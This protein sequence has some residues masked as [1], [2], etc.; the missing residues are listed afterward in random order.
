MNIEKNYFKDTN[1]KLSWGEYFDRFT[2]NIR[3]RHYD[4]ENY[5]PKFDKLKKSI[6]DNAFNN[7][8]DLFEAVC[9][10]QMINTDIWN[11][12]YDIRRGKEGELGEAEV[13]R[14]AIKI[15]EKNKRRIELVNQINEMFDYHDKEKKFDH[16]SEG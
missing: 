9:E 13:G 11:L 1:I 12:E 5:G 7:A 8:A 4:P 16:V 6:I 10:L 2:I 14:R 15:R 3:K